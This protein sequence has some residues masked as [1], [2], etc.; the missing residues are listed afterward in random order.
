MIGGEMGRDWDSHHT[1]EIK[2]F[3][4][5][6]PLGSDCSIS[7]SPWLVRQATAKGES[8]LFVFSSSL[9]VIVL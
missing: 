2:I 7:F 3:S 9:I 6:I 5:P 8:F 4:K 1:R